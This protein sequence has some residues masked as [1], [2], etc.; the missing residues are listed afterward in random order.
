MAF[1]NAMFAEQ[2]NVADIITLQISSNI[3]LTP[4]WQM[5]LQHLNR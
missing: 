1:Q 4:A 3:A 2:D 5:I